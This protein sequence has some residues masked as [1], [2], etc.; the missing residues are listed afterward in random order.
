[1]NTIAVNGEWLEPG[2]NP[3]NWEAMQ[4]G[5]GIFETIRIQKGVPLHWESHMD[6]LSRS[7]IALGLAKDLKLADLERWASRLLQCQSGSD[8][9]MKLLWCFEEGAGR[10][11]YYFRPLTYTQ[12][13][14]ENG[15]KVCLGTIKRNPYSY[16]TGHKTL[17]YLD[18]L[19]EKRMTRQK[20]FDEALLLNIRDQVAEGTATNLFALKGGVLHTPP[21]EAGLLP[22]IQRAQVLAA[23]KRKGMVY[24]EQMMS[25]DTLIDSDSIFLTNALMGFMP[26]SEFNGKCYDRN[27]SL[28]AAINAE[29]GIID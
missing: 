3:I 22:G 26:V 20:G 25:L 23:C 10:A 8:L 1:M 27:S 15:L 28:T 11:V 29:I 4:F 9:A 13:Q 6:R 18:N 5:A 2:E 21:S 14:R 24:V 19:I 7:A 16:V 17:N 12:E